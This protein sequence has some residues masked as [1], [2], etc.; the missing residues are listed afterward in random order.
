MQDEDG[1]AAE[2]ARHEEDL[3]LPGPSGLVDAQPTRTYDMPQQQHLQMEDGVPVGIVSEP[4]QELDRWTDSTSHTHKAL[5]TFRYRASPCQ[6]Y[7]DVQHG[8]YGITASTSTHPA[9][10]EDQLTWANELL[11][12]R[13]MVRRTKSKIVYNWDNWET[14]HF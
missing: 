1:A 12:C 5:A 3:Y 13:P 10:L 2:D 8:L 14:Y 6:D 7:G 9:D 11:L 4:V